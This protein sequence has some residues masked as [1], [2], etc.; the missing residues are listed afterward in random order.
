MEHSPFPS[1]KKMRLIPLF[2]R[3]WRM[4]LHNPV[5]ECPSDHPL[6][7]TRMTIIGSSIGS[8][9]TRAAR[10][11][12]VRASRFCRRMTARMTMPHTIVM[13]RAVPSS[14]E[15]A[16]AAASRTR[17]NRTS[18]EEERRS[19]QGGS[20]AAAVGSAR[21]RSSQCRR[22]KRLK[23]EADHTATAKAQCGGRREESRRSSILLRHALASLRGARALRINEVWPKSG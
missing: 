8:S 1:L 4:F 12:P 7:R 21:S 10:T 20:A 2:W 5:E 14:V 15:E 13:S 3:R 23:N 17:R 9:S 11:E 16:T 22:R 18:R 6:R 19:K